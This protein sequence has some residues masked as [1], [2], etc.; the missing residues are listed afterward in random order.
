[1][2]PHS[3]QS[4][5]G[6]LKLRLVPDFFRAVRAG[7]G[8]LGGVIASACFSREGLRLG[9]IRNAMLLFGLFRIVAVALIHPLHMSML[10]LQEFQA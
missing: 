1:M 2:E 5:L 8:C 9:C 10:L 4:R 6:G 3:P 7:R